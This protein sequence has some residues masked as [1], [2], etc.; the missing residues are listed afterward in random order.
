MGKN[1]NKAEATENHHQILLLGLSHPQILKQIRQVEVWF[2]ECEVVDVYME[3][4]EID[5][6]TL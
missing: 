3:D 4:K 2:L 1:Q 5:G 6:M